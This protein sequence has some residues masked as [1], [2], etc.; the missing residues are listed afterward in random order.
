MFKIY[1]TLDIEIQKKLEKA[2]QNLCFSK[3]SCKKILLEILLVLIKIL[4]YKYN[5]IVNSNGQLIFLG[6]FKY[7][8]MAVI[9]YKNR[10]LV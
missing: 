10:R 3:S 9:L 2:Y 8:Y 7:D 5:N 6:E 4:L 1:I